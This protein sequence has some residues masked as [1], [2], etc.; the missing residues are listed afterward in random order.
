MHTLRQSL[1]PAAL[2][3]LCW[4]LQPARALSVDPAEQAEAR[5]WVA[6]KLEGKPEPNPAGPGL[7]VL[8]NYKEVEKNGRDGQPLKIG[9]TQYSQGLYCHAPS[10][11]VVRLPGPGKAFSAVVGIDN[12]GNYGGG[13]VVFKV[14]VNGEDRFS[15]PVMHRGEAGVPV[16][17]ELGGATEFVIA[18]TDAGD[19]FN[20]DQASWAQAKATLADGREVWLGDLP[21]VPQTRPVY[22]AEAPFSFHYDGQSSAELLKLWPVKRST[23]P[24]DANRT[25]LTL[26]WNDPRTGLQVRCVAVV[27]QDFPTV[28]WTVYFKN[29]GTKDTPILANIEALDSV[30][31]RRGETEFSLHHHKGT[32]VRADDFEPLTTILEPRRELAFA[33]P[34]GRPLGQVFPYYNL[35]WS[36]EGRIIVVG[37]PGQWSA[38][39]T[40]DDGF[41]VRVVA[42][43]ERTRLHLQPGEEI[44]TPLIVLQFYQGDWIRGQNVWRRWMVAHNL[45]RRD[46]KLPEPMMPAVSGNQFPGLLCNEADE[47]RYIDRYLEEG[48]K[49]THWWMDAGWYINQGDWTSVG[50]WEIDTNRFPRGLRSI[51]DHVHA[52][53]IKLLVWFEPERVTAGSWLAEQHP[54]WVLGGKQGGL[55]NLGHPDAWNWLVNHYDKFLTEQ[56]IDFYRQDFNMDPLASW[57]QND[58]PERQGITEIKHVQGYLAF[59]D[60]LVRRH[61]A[62]LIDSC[63]SGGHRND[64][65]TLRR[66]LPLLRSDYIFDSIGEQCH[67]LGLAPWMPFY[68]TGFIDYSPYIVRSLMGPNTTLSCDA[69]RKDLDWDLLRKLVAQWREIVPN[70]FGD[71]YPLTPY[72]LAKDAWVAWQFDRPEA[73]EGIVQ[74]FR[75]D[76]C[77]V[78]SVEL[79]LQ[80]LD[81]AASYNVVNLDANQTCQLS[82]KALMDQGLLVEIP[83]RAA[84]AVVRYAKVKSASA[85]GGAN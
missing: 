14:S 65:E 61:P 51:S 71:F 25:E 83:A 13:T 81:P 26:S 82:G 73:G 6:A 8:A 75:R 7:V 29:T 2:A 85:S 72:S 18:V 58:A 19:N 22:T 84:A 68:G 74:A 17:V 78:R 70:Y 77:I 80:G 10:R 31:E 32:F 46:G 60:E 21:L 9:G 79:R 76:E 35:A 39:F 3:A 63:A 42:G 49:I 11:I 37:W 4:T 27:Y 30:I 41:G 62:M 20:S 54:D 64:L 66:A 59:W 34:G 5:R 1:I 43:Q 33:P 15:S 12:N 53:G 28:E 48:I 40:R 47:L 44:R 50:T 38:R 23:R 67:T 57:R 36:G 52:R 56:G 55:L 69:R 45:P 24:L 16:L